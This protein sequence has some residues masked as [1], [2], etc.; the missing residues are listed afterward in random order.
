MSSDLWSFALACY[1]RPGVEAACLH[2]Q[3]GGAD[4]CLLLCGLWLEQRGVPCESARVRALRQIAQPWQR[5]VV[6]PLREL[7]Q[8]WR[9]AAR[10]D[11]L[12]SGW[13]ERIKVLELE[14]ERELLRRL[15]EVTSAWAP[16]EATSSDWLEALAGTEGETCRDALAELRAAAVEA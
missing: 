1:Q 3:A 15:E 5:D 10:H 13:R 11:E 8:H 16:S 2:L 7:R 6:Q 9:E 14:S 4:V 12:L